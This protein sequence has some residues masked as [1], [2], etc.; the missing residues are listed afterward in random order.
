MWNCNMSYISMSHLHG[1]AAQQTLNLDQA[2]VGDGVDAEGE[3]N[4][5]SCVCTGMER[6]MHVHRHTYCIHTHFHK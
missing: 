4:H 6:G 3:G 1:E 5:R 2:S